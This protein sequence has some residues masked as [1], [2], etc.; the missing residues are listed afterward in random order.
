MDMNRLT[1][2]SQEALQEAQSAAG[3]RATP[4]WT[5]NTCC[6][7]CSASEDGLI[8][9]CCSRPAPIPRRSRGRPRGAGPQAQGDRSGRGVGPGLRHPAPRPGCWTRPTGGQTA[10]G[11]VRLR[12]APA[13]R[14][15]RRGLGDCGRAAA[16]GARRHPGELPRR[17]SPRSAATSASRP[18]IPR[19][20]TRRWR[21][22]AATWSPR[23][24]AG[25]STRSSAGMRRSGAS[26]RSS[27]VRRRTTPSSSATPESARPRSSKGLAQRIVSGDVPEGLR[28]KTVFSLDI[29]SLVAGAKYRGEFEERLQGRA[30]RG[31][32]RRG[33]DPALRRR[34]AQR[35]R[36]RAPPRARWTRATCSSRCSPAANCT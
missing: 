13:A 22:T 36:A 29:S 33:A 32:G 17:R 7:G 6:S 14:D 23:P 4:K 10:Q 16:R 18:P 28:E 2:K 25:G 34:A 8:P 35:R 5:A 21:S 9:G 27:A 12:G 1:Q 30:Q 20:P 19:A 24:G 15:G 31:Q 26:S 3:G 11:R